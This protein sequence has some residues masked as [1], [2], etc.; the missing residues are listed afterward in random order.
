MQIQRLT[1]SDARDTTGIT[2][3]FPK[4]QEGFAPRFLPQ[5]VRHLTYEAYPRRTTRSVRRR[6]ASFKSRC[7]KLSDNELPGLTHQCPTDP[8]DRIVPNA[9][10]RPVEKP[11]ELL[12]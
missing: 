2:K 6:A 10:K 1:I 7:G 11:E 5:A 12:A 8:E 3:L 9:P 4:E